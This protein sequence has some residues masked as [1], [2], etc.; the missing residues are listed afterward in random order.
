MATVSK[1]CNVSYANNVSFGQ[2]AAMQ[3]QSGVE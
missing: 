2:V 1:Q 3:S